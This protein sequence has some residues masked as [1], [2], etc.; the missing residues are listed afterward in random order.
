MDY[1]L[2]G[3]HNRTWHRSTSNGVCHGSLPVYVSRTSN[4]SHGE[5][6]AIP[7]LVRQ[8][9][10]AP[11]FTSRVSPVPYQQPKMLPHVPK[12]DTRSKLSQSCES[13]RPSEPFEPSELPQPS[14]SSQQSER[15]PDPAESMLT[16]ADSISPPSSV[17]GASSY[18]T[19]EE[20]ESTR[21]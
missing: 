10:L 8:S 21:C 12:P 14:W 2:S 6:P 17:G 4:S 19:C 16:L 20:A 1:K 3:G 7:S 5:T 11:T 15:A 18:Q 13:I 9:T